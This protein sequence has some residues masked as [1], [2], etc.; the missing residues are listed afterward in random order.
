MKFYLMVLNKY[1]G[2]PYDSVDEAEEAIK[3]DPELLKI[4]GNRILR[5][6]VHICAEDE[7]ATVDLSFPKENNN[8]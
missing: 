4:N 1:I 3:N 6:K 8:V 2:G 5:D 7:D